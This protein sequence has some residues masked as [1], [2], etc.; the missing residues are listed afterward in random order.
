MWFPSRLIGKSKKF[1]KGEKVVQELL[2][3]IAI[4]LR[5][6]FRFYPQCN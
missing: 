3:F 5:K 6:P 1:N 4:K 2:I